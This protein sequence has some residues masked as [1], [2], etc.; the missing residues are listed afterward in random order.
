MIVMFSKILERLALARLKPHIAAS[1]NFCALQSAYRGAHSTETA[2]VKVVDDLLTSIDAGSVVALVGLD[3][4]AA[5]DTVNHSVLLDRLD[6]EFGIADLPLKWIASYLAGR[7]V[8]VRVGKSTSTSVPSGSGVP[9]GSVL[10]PILFTTYISP[11]GRLITSH[12][13]N[14]HKY[15][16]DTQ[17]Y[18]SLQPSIDL[19]LDSLA[20][21]TTHLQHWY[22]SNDLLLNPDKS[23][24]AFF[25]TR[26]RFQRISLPTH[27]TVA[28][29]SV[30]VSDTLK[31]LGVK[32]DRTLSFDNHIS[33]LVRGCNYHLWA[34]RH[35]RS[36]LTRDTA[37]TMAC[38]IVGS[39]MDY[40]NALFSGMS[41]KKL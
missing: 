30:A 41:E 36:S 19:S 14:F 8:R 25:G 27:V 26:Q 16:D 28:G 38:S 2:L 37:N 13:I 24:V 34:L 40:C 17:L 9:Q 4:S 1:P 12:R 7:S 22:W 29:S 20:R 18:I 21:C 31:T 23:E 39:R 3:I 6:R 11:V 15:A 35:L 33:D 10:G 5:F 32:L